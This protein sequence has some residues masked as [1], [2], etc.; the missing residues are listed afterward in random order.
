[1]IAG[2]VGSLIPL[3]ALKAPPGFSKQYLSTT[4][5]VF[6]INYDFLR[7]HKMILTLPEDT[8]P[9]VIRP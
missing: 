6:R 7:Q 5:N 4:L 1:M 8:F 3:A 9:E 2:T